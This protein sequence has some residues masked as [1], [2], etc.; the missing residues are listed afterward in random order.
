MSTLSYLWKL[1][2]ET[3][4]CLKDKAQ[5]ANGKYISVTNGFLYAVSPTLA[6]IEDELGT[7]IIKS[8]EKLGHVTYVITPKED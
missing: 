7:D 3:T 4:G 1:E 6:L 5:T 2:V 8:A